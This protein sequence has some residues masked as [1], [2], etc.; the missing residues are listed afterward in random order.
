MTIRPGL[1]Y[2]YKHPCFDW[3]CSQFYRYI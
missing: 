1:T 2:L 3:A